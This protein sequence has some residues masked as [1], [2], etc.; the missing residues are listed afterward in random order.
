MHGSMHGTESMLRPAPLT[1]GNGVP[2][3]RS[4]G[5]ARLLLVAVFQQYLF[6]NLQYP[7]LIAARVLSTLPWCRAR[8]NR[9][10]VISRPCCYCCLGRVL[11][12]DREE[13]HTHGRTKAA[14]SDQR[15]RGKELGTACHPPAIGSSDQE[16]GREAHAHRFWAPGRRFERHQARASQRDPRACGGS[17]VMRQDRALRGP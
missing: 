17:P 6:E 15:I 5:L 12:T 3:L 11:R 1:S 10:R 9:I 7:S 4:L 13:K 8:H 2:A 14:K 16:R